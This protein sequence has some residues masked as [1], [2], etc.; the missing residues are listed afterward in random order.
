MHASDLPGFDTL[1]EQSPLRGDVFW[2]YELHEM[3]PMRV[4]FFYYRAKALGETDSAKSLIRGLQNAL[5]QAKNQ[6][7]LQ[8]ADLT[9]LTHKVP[10]ELFTVDDFV[11]ALNQMT[12]VRQNAILLALE[13]GMDID[14]IINLKWDEE[15]NLPSTAC[16]RMV[17]GHQA[18]RRHV[19]LPYVFWEWAGDTALPLLS[20]MADAEFAFGKSWPA[21]ICSYSEMSMYSA[22]ADGEHVKRLLDDL[23]GIKIRPSAN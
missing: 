21:I 4:N 6:P 10:E 3:T 16:V 20:L 1:I 18:Q 22:R 2:K 5:L 12:D 9:L 23:H 19:S 15:V 7:F 14:R 17:L 13:S 8:R 11:D